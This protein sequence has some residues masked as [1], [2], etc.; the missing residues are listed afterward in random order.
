ML[1]RRRAKC[2]HVTFSNLLWRVWMRDRYNETCNFRLLLGPS[3]FS[4]DGRLTWYLFWFV[5]T[6]IWPIKPYAFQKDIKSPIWIYEWHRS[7]EFLA[8]RAGATGNFKCFSDALDF[9]HLVYSQ[10]WLE[11]SFFRRWNITYII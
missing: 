2:G 9:S 7:K 3:K 8:N 5:T 1:D 11:V 6:V 4:V 10:K